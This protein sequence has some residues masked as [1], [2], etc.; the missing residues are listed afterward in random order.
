MKREAVLGATHED[1][2]ETMQHL[3]ALLLSNGQYEEALMLFRHAFERHRERHSEDHPS[4]V[5]AQQNLAFALHRYEG[6]L[7][8]SFWWDIFNFFRLSPPPPLPPFI[9]FCTLHGRR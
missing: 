5:N 1:T 6:F 3:G 2:L 7:C 4:T 9:R 8:V